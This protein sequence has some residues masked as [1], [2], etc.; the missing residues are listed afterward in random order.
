M[1]PK[2]KKEKRTQLEERNSIQLT[3]QEPSGFKKLSNYK[4]PKKAT[5]Y[6]RQNE[7]QVGSKKLLNYRALQ[8]HLEDLLS[9]HNEILKRSFSFDEQT[10]RESLTSRYIL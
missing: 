9:P 2:K 7:N 8:I 3:K 6:N 4:T 5:E 1:E 10:S